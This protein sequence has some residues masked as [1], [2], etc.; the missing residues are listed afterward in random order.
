[1]TTGPEAAPPVLRARVG[2]F[3][4]LPE[5]YRQPARFRPT[6]VVERA[7]GEGYRV[8]SSEDMLTTGTGGEAVADLQ[9]ALALARHDP[10]PSD[11][12]FGPRTEDAV[13]AF[14]RQR[15]L[16]VDGL[17][18]PQTV[19]ELTA[20]FL[21]RFLEGLEDVVAP[22][23]STLD[24]LG[25]Y[26]SVDTAPEHFLA[27]L[28][29]VVG[30]DDPGV[31]TQRRRDVVAQALELHRWEGT[32]R[33]IAA[34]VAA[35][36]GLS[37]A[38]VAVTDGGETAWDADPAAGLA[39]PASRTVVVRVPAAPRATTAETV[40]SLVEAAL[41]VGLSVELVMEART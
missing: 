29:W 14:Q 24:N 39:G 2:F 18:G 9:R 19:G 40:R 8:V 37:P 35:Q 41:P 1:M 6:V 31:A 36:L 5:V 34:L 21:R 23:V 20:P 28:A 27:W 10:G 13:R 12:D 26:V 38:D 11:G 22:V 7:D 17:V 25:G 32:V 15:G 16:V 3:E 4:R 33:G 30:A